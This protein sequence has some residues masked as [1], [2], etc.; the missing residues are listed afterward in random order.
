MPSFDI[1]SEMDKQEIDNALNQARK[2]LATR[3]DFKG[4]VAGD[5]GT[6]RTRSP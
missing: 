5:R 6:K 2:E 3:F 4:S 1:V